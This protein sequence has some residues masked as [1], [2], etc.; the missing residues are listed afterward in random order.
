MLAVEQRVEIKGL[1]FFLIVVAD[2]QAMFAIGDDLGATV[3]ALYRDLPFGQHLAQG[4]AQD[5]QDQLSRPVDVEEAREPARLAMGQHVVPPAIAATRDTHMI[6]HDVDD[7]AHAPRSGRLGERTKRFL[8]AEFG[9]DPRRVDYV[10]PMHRALCRRGD[11][12]GIDMA[13]P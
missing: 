9:I 11:R 10:I 7:G 12:R 5:R 1:G 2:R 4:I 8:A 6:G 3:A 13:D